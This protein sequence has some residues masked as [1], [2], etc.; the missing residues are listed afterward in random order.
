ML[1]AACMT[2]LI[3]KDS[4]TKNDL[5]NFVKTELAFKGTQILSQDIKE[6]DKVIDIVALGKIIPN[7]VIKKAAS[8]LAEY[9]LSGYKLNVIQ[10]EQ[11]DSLLMINKQLSNVAVSNSASNQ[12]IIEQSN[13]IHEL[14]D[15]LNKYKQYESV[16]HDMT[17][18]LKVLFPSVVKI[19]IS[20]IKEVRTDSAKQIRY[21][22]AVVN[23][24]SK[25]NEVN[26]QRFQ[27]WLKERTKADSLRLIITP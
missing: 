24:R 20:N 12:K 18:E 8:R 14:E 7:N 10:G 27:L 1:P 17:G 19:S 16:A 9:Q 13:Q 26:R 22:M 6:G 25:F 5:R 11:S 2:M 21:V 4:I 23:S 3:I 15:Q